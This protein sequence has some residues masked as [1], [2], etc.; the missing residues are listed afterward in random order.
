MTLVVDP[1]ALRTLAEAWEATGR[2]TARQATTVRGVGAGAHQFGRIH[3]F[4]TPAL[5]WFVERAVRAVE[6][7]GEE[8]ERGALALRDTARDVVDTDRGVADGWGEDG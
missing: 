2:A 5:D 3:Q 1:E 8:W 7:A 6:H 4:V